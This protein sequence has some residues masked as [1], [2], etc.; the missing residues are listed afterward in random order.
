MGPDTP[1]QYLR[2]VG[3]E[4]AKRLAKLGI[5][6]LTDLVGHLPRQHDDRRETT[7]IGK[8]QAESHVNVRGKVLRVVKRRLRSARVR[9]V[10]TAVIEDDSGFV[11]AEFWNQGWRKDQLEGAEDVL[12]SGR[13]TWDGQGPVMKGPEV[14][15][16]SEGDEEERLLHAGR[17][18]PIHPLTQGIYATRMR[19]VVHRALPFVVDTL[20]D[21]LPAA[22]LHERGMPDLATA[23]REAHF[24]SSMEALDEAIRR[25]KYQ[26]LFLLQVALARRRLRHATEEKPHVVQVSARL[27]SRIRARFPFP[28]TGAQD[29][30]VREIAD[31]LASPRP[32]NRLLQGDVGAGK[33]VVAAYGMLSTVAHRMQAALLA[34]TEILAEQHYTT[35]CRYLEGS[36]VRLALVTGGARS[37]QRRETLKALAAHD[38]DI[39]VG[40]HALIQQDVDFS[41]LAFVVVD[42]QHKFGVLQR[43]ALRDKGL[44][45]DLL[46]MSATP[47][48]RT[49]TMTLFGDL[50]VSV[51]DE[52]P[53]G[54]KPVQ[55]MLCREGDRR[56]AY[57]WVRG[58]IRRGRRVFHVC[59][60]VEKSE[61]LPLRAAVQFRDEL[62]EGPFHDVAV[63]L[64][65]GKMKSEEKDAAMEAFRSGSTPVLVCT[66]VVEVGVDVP[67]ATVLIV[68]H[69]ERFGLA[70]LHQLRGRIGRGQHASRMI[71]FHE[72]RSKDARERLK[73]LAAT[74]DG[75]RIA[76]DDLRIRGPGEFLGTRQSGVPELRLA[77][78][79]TDALLLSEARR[80]AF[81]L[82]ER[83]PGLTKEGAAAGRALARTLAA[84]LG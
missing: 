32:M 45:P 22:L 33:T 58:E 19:A 68:E 59:P 54:R 77:N 64:L 53:P 27:D 83:D 55:T 18:V 11:Q 69:A 39:A 30:C 9:S 42:E 12:L 5:H 6:T 72:A 20:E 8:I 60:L 46:V 34:P 36:Q 70:Q 52:L 48:P 82:V 61:E 7:P 3:P 81:A 41:R 47:I 24:P 73:A 56:R 28:L 63:G 49:L 29:R 74:T 10:V 65:H 43:A 78:L 44:H 35:L 80:D 26:E 62:A 51:L 50:D 57:D 67:E 76:E 84:L 17:I 71:C 75:F 13:V 21:P 31:D 23:L 1:V 16:L 2:G 40:T 15:V 14:E 38:I 66:S 37:K 79:V 25:L 4:R